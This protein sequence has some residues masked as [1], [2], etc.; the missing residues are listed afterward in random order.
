[1]ECARMS[2]TRAHC[3]YSKF[4]V[5]AAILWDNGEVTCGCNVENASYGL[6][7]CA[8]RNA[9]FAGKAKG[10]NKIL[11]VA[12]ACPDLSDGF[13]PKYSMSCGCCRQ[14][15]AEFADD[16]VAI[17]I[18]RVGTYKLRELLPEAFRL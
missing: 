10:F 15:I 1:M 2:S 6:T 17:Q 8:E 11:R 18:D 5:G 16:D 7:I 14:V 4:H 13:D 3:P 12:V 9:V